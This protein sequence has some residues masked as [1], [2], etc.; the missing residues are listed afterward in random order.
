MLAELARRA[1]LPWW[2]KS[3]AHWPMAARAAFVVLGAGIAAAFVFVA[4]SAQAG[5]EPGV[6]AAFLAKDYWPVLEIVSVLLFAALAGALLLGGKGQNVTGI[7][8]AEGK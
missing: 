1:A 4:V 2:R 8:E 6:L 3:F 5:F 7:S